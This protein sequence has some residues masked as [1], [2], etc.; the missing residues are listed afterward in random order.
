MEHGVRPRH[1]RPQLIFG[2]LAIMAEP[3]A[4]AVGALPAGGCYIPESACEVRRGAGVHVA[5][6]RQVELIIASTSVLLDRPLRR[7]G[8]DRHRRAWIAG[9][10]ARDHRPTSRGR[11]ASVPESRPVLSPVPVELD[12]VSVPCVV[13]PGEPLVSVPAPGWVPCRVEPVSDGLPVPEVPVVPVSPADPAV[14]DGAAVPVP[15]VIPPLFAPVPP[16]APP[17]VPAAPPAVPPDVPPGVSLGSVGIGL[18]GWLLLRS[19]SLRHPPAIAA[20]T[21][22]AER[23]I[24]RDM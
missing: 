20:D 24:Q 2:H 3:R 1:G 12:G 7:R 4:I 15:P 22:I 6:E 21:T 19:W 11:P 17:A 8:D 10:A 16:V 14:P 9:S 5:V 13:P 18:G 23:K